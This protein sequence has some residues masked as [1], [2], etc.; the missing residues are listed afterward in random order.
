MMLKNR[1]KQ[2]EYAQNQ[3]SSRSYAT[4]VILGNNINS[5]GIEYGLVPYP[6]GDTLYLTTRKKNISRR[7]DRLLF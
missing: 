2:L 7:L 6:L 3:M 5:R 4:K 1:L